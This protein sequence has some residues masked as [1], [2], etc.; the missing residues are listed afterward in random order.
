[1]HYR[2]TIIFPSLDSTAAP[3]L[4]QFLR[5]ISL[6]TTASLPS[7]LLFGLFE[8][9]VGWASLKLPQNRFLKLSF[10]SK[11]GYNIFCIWFANHF[12]NEF[13]KFETKQNSDIAWLEFEWYGGILTF[14]ALASETCKAGKLGRTGSRRCLSKN[15][16]RT[17]TGISSLLRANDYHM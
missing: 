9:R 17:R 15:Y 4:L 3:L 5:S 11:K 2:P 6:S 14:K 10:D 1:M 7:Q 8:E 16:C 13:M 12:S